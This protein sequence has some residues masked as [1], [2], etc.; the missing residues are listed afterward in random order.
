MVINNFYQIHME[1]ITTAL[2]Y[3]LFK[4]LNIIVGR[5]KNGS[6]VCY[7]IDQKPSVFV[8]KSCIKG[9]I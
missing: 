1:L 6:K 7:F 3:L 4:F 2:F 8:V 5:F 9:I